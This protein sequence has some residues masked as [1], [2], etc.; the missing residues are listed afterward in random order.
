MNINEV[1]S[2]VNECKPNQYGDK[3]MI[4]WLS[5]LEGKI[6][7]EVF[8]THEGEHIEFAGY[9]ENDINT[10][11]LVPDTYADVYR[12]YIYA[13]IDFHNGEYTRYAASMTVFNNAMQDFK[14]YYNRTHKPLGG[15][16]KIF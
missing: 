8:N 7:D 12:Y 14:N 2:E 16:L 6:V 11:L 4:G 5:V 10:E 13:M 15:P 9:T 3:T 1:L